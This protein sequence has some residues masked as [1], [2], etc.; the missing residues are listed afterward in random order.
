MPFGVLEAHSSQV[1]VARIDAQEL[2][3]EP[4]RSRARRHFGIAQGHDGVASSD[5]RRLQGLQQQSAELCVD[6]D[7]VHDDVHARMIEL[8]QL[9]RAAGP[10]AFRKGP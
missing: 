6:D 4:R 9:D 8:E 1:D 7:V 5:R 10:R 2:R 3:Q